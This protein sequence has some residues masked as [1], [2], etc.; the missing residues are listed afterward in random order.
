M[1]VIYDRYGRMQYDPEIHENH[2]KTWSEEEVEY[3][4]EWYSKLGPEEMSFSLGRTIQTVM[5]KAS[6]LG[7][8][9]ETYHKRSVP[10]KPTSSAN[11]IS[12]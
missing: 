2:G 9:C 3:L 6:S 1:T 10:K 4:K 5:Q 11:E 12:K 7:I 8:K